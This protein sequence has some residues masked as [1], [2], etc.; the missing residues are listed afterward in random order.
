MLTFDGPYGIA[1][2]AN[3]SRYRSGLF[4]QTMDFGVKRHVGHDRFSVFNPII[5][6]PP[7][8]ALELVGAPP[9]VVSRPAGIK[10]DDC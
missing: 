5:Q 8:K 9:G 10:R 6:C 4:K 7:G 2:A 1:A 3:L